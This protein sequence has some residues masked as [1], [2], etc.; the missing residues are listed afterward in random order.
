LSSILESRC[1]KVI[2]M[3]SLFSKSLTWCLRLS[4]PSRQL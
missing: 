2:R 4:L 1:C 3:P